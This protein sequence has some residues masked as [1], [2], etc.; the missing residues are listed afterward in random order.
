MCCWWNR[1]VLMCHVGDS[2]ETGCVTQQI[3]DDDCQAVVRQG[4]GMRVRLRFF[5]FFFFRLA[6][7]KGVED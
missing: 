6:S 5:F 4:R 2:E 1:T 7:G 3:V